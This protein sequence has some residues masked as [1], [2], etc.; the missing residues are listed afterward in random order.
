MRSMPSVTPQLV[1]PSMIDFIINGLFRSPLIPSIVATQGAFIGLKLSGQL[2]WGWLSVLS[3]TL[4]LI[5]LLG[6]GALG[7]IL[8]LMIHEK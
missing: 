3:P 2:A 4:T 5:F 8:M 7:V 1:P 6:I